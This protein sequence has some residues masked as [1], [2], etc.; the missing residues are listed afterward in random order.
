MA[1]GNAKAHAVGRLVMGMKKQKLGGKINRRSRRKAAIN[2]FDSGAVCSLRL[3][4][5]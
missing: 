2:F 3:P 5:H 1:G 4:Q